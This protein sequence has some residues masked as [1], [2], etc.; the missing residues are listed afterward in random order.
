M[1]LD[2]KLNKIEELGANLIKAKK[3][4]VI[5]DYDAEQAREKLSPAKSR[6]AVAKQEWDNLE[7]ERSEMDKK[8]RDFVEGKGVAIEV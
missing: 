5:A 6:Y 1:N 8:T 7:F 4:A 3:E 2:E